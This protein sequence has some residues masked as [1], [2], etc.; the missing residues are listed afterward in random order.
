MTYLSRGNMIINMKLPD[1][2]V[3]RCLRQIGWSW[4]ICLQKKPLNIYILIYVL[5]F[6]SVCVGLTFFSVTV[7]T[8][9]SL[10]PLHCKFLATT[11]THTHTHCPHIMPS[12]VSTQESVGWFVVIY[13]LGSLCDL[14]S[15][16]NNLFF[17]SFFLFAS[18]FP[19]FISSHHSLMIFFPNLA[20]IWPYHLPKRGV[21]FYPS[22]FYQPFFW[23]FFFFFPVLNHFSKL[24]SP[25]LII[26]RFANPGCSMP[27]LQSG[28][29]HRCG[30][31]TKQCPHRAAAEGGETAGSLQ[32]HW[33]RLA[34]PGSNRS[35]GQVWRLKT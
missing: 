5:R 25:N 4:Y 21:S 33:K 12:Y 34:A 16:F 32:L 9:G 31:E 18:L 1:I 26:E 3:V 13:P 19:G 24:H 15:S 30:Q 35:G 17:S 27:P 7:I 8:F 28:G 14:E 10:F 11:D 29:V 2:P 20:D 22:S 6:V 23:Y